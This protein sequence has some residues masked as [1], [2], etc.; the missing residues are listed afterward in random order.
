MLFAA[1][2]CMP[3]W[4]ISLLRSDR[5]SMRRR[6]VAVSTE[7]CTDHPVNSAP[8]LADE[9][10]SRSSGVKPPGS[11][12]ISTVLS[13]CLGTESF[14]CIGAPSGPSSSTARLRVDPELPLGTRCEAWRCMTI[15]VAPNVV[16]GT[17]AACC[18]GPLAWRRSATRRRPAPAYSLPPQSRLDVLARWRRSTHTMGL[19]RLQL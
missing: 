1:P 4:Q 8:H 12:G 19:S 2:V 3:V 16:G 15:F 11:C 7:G 18:R 17:A 9:I 10:A 14:G 13:A 5:C 6:A